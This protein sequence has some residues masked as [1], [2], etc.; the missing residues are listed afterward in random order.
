MVLRAPRSNIGGWTLFA[1]TAAVVSLALVWNGRRAASLNRALAR[2]QVKSGA[3]ATLEKENRRLGSEQLTAAE[4]EQLEEGH[5]RAQAL[6]ARILALQRAAAAGPAPDAKRE[7]VAQNWKYSGNATPRDAL[8]SVL[9][10]ASRGDVDTLAGLIGFAPDV[11]REA[12]AMFESLPAQAR[13]DYGSPEK[14]VATLLSGTFP[15]D[16]SAASIVGTDEADD[17]ASIDMRVSRS[18]GQSRA[19]SFRLGHAADGWRLLVP[20]GVLAGYER[21]LQGDAPSPENVG[22]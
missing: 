22:P 2:E 5:L 15:K 14:V 16:A 3:L 8:L 4:R 10:A 21:I 18:D 6:R 9:W 19:N 12:E 20:A 17:E 11:R 7:T 1:A 13:A